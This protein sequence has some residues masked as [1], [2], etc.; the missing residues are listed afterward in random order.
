MFELYFWLAL[1]L[2]LIPTFI[3]A[4][5]NPHGRIGRAIS[6][7]SPLRDVNE[8]GAPENESLLARVRLSFGE[9]VTSSRSTGKDFEVE[10]AQ[11]KVSIEKIRSAVI[12]PLLY[13]ISFLAYYL[14]ASLIVP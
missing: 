3:I 4:T 10:I 11:N 1:L 5:N 9:L 8:E 13:L 7:L 2:L 12:T 6:R 14:Y